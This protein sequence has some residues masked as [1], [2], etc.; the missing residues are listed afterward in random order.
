MKREG[1][2]SQEERMVCVK[3]V[4][5][6]GT[7]SSATGLYAG[8]EKGRANSRVRDPRCEV[9]PHSQTL[10]QPLVVTH[11]QSTR[12][13]NFDN[14]FIEDSLPDSPPSPTPHWRCIANVRHALYG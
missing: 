13:N 11:C 4:A 3:A 8:G 10:R 14:G 2:E 6:L 1:R 7:L 5:C 9:P 12:Q